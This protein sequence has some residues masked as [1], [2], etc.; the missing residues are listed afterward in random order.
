VGIGADGCAG[1]SSRAAGAVASARVL[2]G[3]A[4]HLAFFPQFQGERI[5]LDRNLA[6][7]L[8]RIAVLADED[9]V[10]VLASGD[11][12]FFGIGARFLERMPVEDLEFIPHPSSVQWA[13]ARAGVAWE[14]AAFVSLH[15]RGREGLAARVRRRRKVALL[16]DRVNEPPALARHLL[17]HGARDLQ[18]VLCED[19]GGIGER[20]RRCA[21][22]ELAALED[23]RS[24]NVLLLLRPDGWSPPPTIPCLPDDAFERRR[25]LV[26]KREIRLLAL[27]ALGLRDDSVVWDVGAGSGSVAVEAA[28]VA[29][30]GRV[31]AVESDPEAAERCRRN[32]RAHGADNVRLVAGRA[33]EALDG[34]EAPDAVF[35]GGSG[36]RLSEILT[37]A[38]ARLRPGGRLVVSAVTLETLEEARRSLGDLGLAT[39]VTL[40]SLARSAPL[41]GRTRLVPGSPV[42][43]VAAA[44]PSGGSP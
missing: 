44:K 26:T 34:L 30:E 2:A 31:C 36:G 41:A 7:A 40:A 22:E 27:G 11:P 1:L 9:P 33:P 21:L 4:R 8:D 32:A 14:D 10:C 19:L 28:L 43:L 12:L 18:A 39:E 24:L 16:T 35:V 23:V 5:A 25:G 3:G 37:L 20:V 38:A 29:C 15:G 42:H 17:E 6:A 13:F